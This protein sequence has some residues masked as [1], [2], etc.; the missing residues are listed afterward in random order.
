MKLFTRLRDKRCLSHYTA[1]KL[2]LAIEPSSGSG[3]TEKKEKTA[4][5]PTA[6]MISG[7]R[8]QGKGRKRGARKDG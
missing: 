4:K 3:A 2:L 5:N 1:T 7:T 8:G 6:A